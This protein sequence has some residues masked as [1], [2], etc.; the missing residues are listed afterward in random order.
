M[1]SE[2]TTMPEIASAKGLLAVLQ[3]YTSMGMPVLPVFGAVDGHCTCKCQA[4]C[5]KNAGKH[6][7]AKFVPHGV[8]DAT[9]DL[10]ILEDWVNRGNGKTNW[11]V[12]TGLELEGGGFLAVLDVDPRNGGD[13]T[14][15]DFIAEYG[16]PAVTPQAITGG[17]GEH[18][19]FRMATPPVPRLLGPGLELKGV[20][21]YVVVDPSMH[22]SG[23]RYRWEVSR[24]LQDTP[25]ADA[26]EWMAEA[27]PSSPRPVWE[28]AS[29]RASYLG[30]AFAVAGLLGVELRN[31]IFAVKCPWH[32]EHT[33]GRGDGGDSSTVLLPPTPDS[34]FGMFKCQ[35]AHCANRTWKDVIAVLSPSAKLAAQRVHGPRAVAAL[36]PP[37]VEA[38]VPLPAAK[39]NPPKPGLVQMRNK[40]ELTTALSPDD[41]DQVRDHLLWVTGKDKNF[42]LRQDIVNAVEILKHDPRWK[43]LLRHNLFADE[44]II[45]RAP[46]WHPDDAPH[47]GNGAYPR[48]MNDADVTLMN[49]WFIR[50]WALWLKKESVWDA[51]IT[52]ARANAFHPVR[53]FLETLVWDGTSRLDTWTLDYCNVKDTEYARMV[54]RWWLI[55]AVARVYMPGCQVDHTLILEGGQGIGKS[56]ALRILGGQWYTGSHIDLESKDGLGVLHG[57][58][59]VELQELDSMKRA[60][61][62]RVK[63]M[64]STCSDRYRP[65]YG[66]LTIDK[67]RQCVFAGTVNDTQ[68]L[69]D[70]TGNR[71]FFPLDCGER[72]INLEELARVRDQLL[73][74]AVARFKNGERFHPESRREKD[75]CRA[76]VVERV[77]E[78]PFHQP[79]QAFIRSQAGR[80]LLYTQGYLTTADIL[81]NALRLD[82]GRWGRSETIRVGIC[83]ADL[84]WMRKRATLHDGT[85]AWIY[86]PTK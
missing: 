17:G 27:T 47:A 25:I 35:H 7:I 86:Q 60:E 80:D 58:W 41:L 64:L 12:A 9:R 37:D 62:S 38:D 49:L 3:T 78:D 15:L 33:D 26:P 69:T 29:A 51:M 73:A 4:T 2:V 84:Q 19:Y 22:L 42:V 59:I 75:L 43:M 10:A 39:P 14:L 81:E 32:D 50:E 82:R 63:A 61:V 72:P 36:P 40:P 56:S 28:G 18:R 34:A 65:P 11:A 16:E 53:E 23:R 1:A 54:S 30:E 13:D 21:N 67:P 76:Q 66:R 45:T 68:Y 20:G 44:I 77:L 52:S 31:G 55:S 48:A 74:E 5:G 70:P 24:H 8:Q 46:P 79:V 71:R 83:F 6:P 85:R 57:A